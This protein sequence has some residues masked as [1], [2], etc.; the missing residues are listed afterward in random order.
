MSRVLIRIHKGKGNGVI[1][2]NRR[3]YKIKKSMPGKS[4][5]YNRAHWVVVFGWEDYIRQDFSSF[6]SGE[7]QGNLEGGSVEYREDFGRCFVRQDGLNN[8]PE[9]KNKYIWSIQNVYT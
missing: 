2:S 8:G 6:F 7:E 3:S 4:K 9:R 1:K 5:G